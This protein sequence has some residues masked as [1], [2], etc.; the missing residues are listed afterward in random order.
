MSTIMVDRLHKRGVLTA[1]RC[2][3]H[4]GDAATLK[5]FDFQGTDVLV[6]CWN[7]GLSRIIYNNVV[8]AAIRSPCVKGRSIV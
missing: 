4:L 3:L 6:Y 7:R 8:D 2:S 5:Q 1:P